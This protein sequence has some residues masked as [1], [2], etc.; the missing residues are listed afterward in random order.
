ME[1]DIAVT[2]L[3]GSPKATITIVEIRIYSADYPS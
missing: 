1:R 2:D 3:S